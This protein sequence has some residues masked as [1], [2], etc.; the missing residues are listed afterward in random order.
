MQC[1]HII[2]LFQTV[3]EVNNTTIWDA[4]KMI[5][6]MTLGA[7]GVNARSEATNIGVALTLFYHGP[8]GSVP[9]ICT[10]RLRRGRLVRLEPVWI[11]SLRDNEW[12]SEVP[13][14][15][16]H[17]WNMNNCFYISHSRPSR[18]RKYTKDWTGGG[19]EGKFLTEKGKIG[20]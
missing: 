10:I 12:G 5:N 14:I 4:N 13:T 6:E 3:A 15:P 9:I 2:C 1:I 17:L 11:S 16:R 18:N 20:S 19:W 7:A 8:I